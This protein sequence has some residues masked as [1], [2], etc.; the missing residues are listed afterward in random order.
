MAKLRL[1]AQVIK[2]NRRAS[3]VLATVIDIAPGK[4]SVQLNHNGARL[5]MLSLAN[6]GV[7]VGDRVIVDYTGDR[8]LVKTIV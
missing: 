1:K 3:Q 5:T 7:K 2:V 8:P 6:T 4:A